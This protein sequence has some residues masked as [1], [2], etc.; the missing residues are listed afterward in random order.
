[1]SEFEL[2]QLSG[3]TPYT[4]CKFIRSYLGDITQFQYTVE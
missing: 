2:I 4:K 3:P 1:M